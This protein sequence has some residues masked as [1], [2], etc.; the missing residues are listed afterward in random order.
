MEKR[1]QKK[2]WCNWG[3][4][5]QSWVHARLSEA[6]AVRF[7]LMCGV[8]SARERK[9]VL[10]FLSDNDRWMEADRQKDDRMMEG[11]AW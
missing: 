2:R 3:E 8:L 4:F 10:H 9:Y 6:P 11:I 7:W 5:L 1:Q